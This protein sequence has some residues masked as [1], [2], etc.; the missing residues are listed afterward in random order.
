[1]MFTILAIDKP[2]LYFL[3]ISHANNSIVIS[4]IMKSTGLTVLRVEFVLH[5]LLK[6]MA[7]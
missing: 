1:M 5:F 7:K 3:D 4:R 6:K 2:T